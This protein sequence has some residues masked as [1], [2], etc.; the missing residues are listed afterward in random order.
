MTHTFN[1]SLLFLVFSF[2]INRRI[3][4]DS[5]IEKNWNVTLNPAEQESLLFYA[6]ADGD[7]HDTVEDKSGCNETVTVVNYKKFAGLLNLPLV[8]PNCVGCFSGEEPSRCL[9]MD[10]DNIGYCG[11]GLVLG[12]EECDGGSGCSA[13]CTCES[14]YVPIGLASCFRLFPHSCVI[15][16]TFKN[17]ITIIYG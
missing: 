4:T 8:R 12:D 3:L 15:R 16:I 10:P 7:T 1:L 2:M 17:L 11:D 5:E 14:G 13:T 9:P 6:T